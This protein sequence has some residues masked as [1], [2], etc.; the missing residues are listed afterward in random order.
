MIFDLTLVKI[1]SHFPVCITHFVKYLVLFPDFR[2]FKAAHF[3]TFSVLGYTLLI[4]ADIFNWLCI[5]VSI[6][7]SEIKLNI[8]RFL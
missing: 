5:R 1:M 2:L 6:F 4:Y 3:P 7:L 8:F